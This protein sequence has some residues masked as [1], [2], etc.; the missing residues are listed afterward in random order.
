MKK[1]TLRKTNLIKIGEYKYLIY[2]CKKHS[3]EIVPVDGFL[4]DPKNM[5]DFVPIINISKDHMANYEKLD[6]YEILCLIN[7]KNPLIKG[8]VQ[9][10]LDKQ[11]KRRF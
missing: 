2:R 1:K 6:D 10:F 11:S 8:L 9:N 5:S 3:L 4:N 7:Q